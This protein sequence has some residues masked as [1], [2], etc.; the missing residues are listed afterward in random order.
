MADRKTGNASALIRALRPGGNCY[1]SSGY[2]ERLLRLHKTDTI[3]E[4]R[5]EDQTKQFIWR[6]LGDPDA[7]GLYAPDRRTV[8]IFLGGK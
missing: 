1:G 5:R 6:I 8:V 2:F 4:L 7:H 3:A